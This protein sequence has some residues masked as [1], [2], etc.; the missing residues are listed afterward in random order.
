MKEIIGTHGT[1][2]KILFGEGS[3]E[4]FKFNVL[5]TMIDLYN[6][7]C[8]SFSVLAELTLSICQRNDEEKTATFTYIGY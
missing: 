7:G 3:T 1:G 8:Q 6:E 4:D 2:Y 5:K